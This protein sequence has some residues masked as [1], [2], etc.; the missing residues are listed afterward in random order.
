MAGTTAYPGALDT[1]TNLNENL[2]DNVDTV[3]AA[4]QNN[5]NAAIKAVQAKVGIGADTATTTQILVGGASAGSSAWVTMSGNAT[6]TNAGVVS[7]TG[8]SFTSTLYV[9]ESAN[10]SMGLGVT[11]NQGAND[12]EVL[13]FKSSDIAHAYT[14]GGETD[15]YAAF[16][17]SSA[18][19]GGLKITSIAEDAAEDQVTQ[20]HSI[21][22]TA[23]TT[24]STSGVGLVDIYVAEHNGSNALADITADG[25][26]FSVRARVGSADV[27][28]F[29]VDEDG[30]AY[31]FGNAIVT[32]SVTAAGSTLAAAGSKS[33]VASG[34][35]GSAGLA[36]ALNA[37][38]TV[39]VVADNRAD[40]SRP[41]TGAEYEAADAEYN[42]CGYNED[43]G[44]IWVAYFDRGVS[45]DPTVCSG[46]V[47]G[48]TITWGTPLAIE[49][50]DGHKMGAVYDTTLNQLWIVY[51]DKAASAYNHRIASCTFGGTGGRTVTKNGTEKTIR[52]GDSGAGYHENQ[53]FFND[54][55]NVTIAAITDAGNSHKTDI[56]K[57]SISGSTITA[58]ASSDITTA[59]GVN[60]VPNPRY[61][62]DNTNAR[63]MRVF[64]KAQQLYCEAYSYNNSTPT[65][66]KTVGPI[67][68]TG[69]WEVKNADN[70][71]NINYDNY[72]K[73]THVMWRA[74]HEDSLMIRAMRL[75]GT[76]L[77]L[78]EVFMAH[79]GGS[80][81]NRGVT[82][83][84]PP[85]AY[86]A[87]D[88]LG[89]G[90]LLLTYNSLD[91]YTRVLPLGIGDNLEYTVAGTEQT[92]SYTTGSGT[93][94]HW[95]AAGHFTAGKMIVCWSNNAGNE[96]VGNIYTMP[97]GAT[98]APKFFGIS[99]AAIS[100]T[101]TGSITIVGGVNTG[102]SGLTR[103]DD[104]YLT[105]AGAY[106]ST[107]S[108][109]NYGK[110]GTATASNNILLTGTGDQS[111]SDA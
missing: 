103:G 34:A 72:N 40:G 30:D 21:G 8:G 28:R 110:I 56:W 91:D 36:V 75:S 35:I 84:Y 109:E 102:V 43:T 92:M 88:A 7:V 104:I 26:V 108:A 64:V 14:T 69:G 86:M 63:I 52:A 23:M 79:Q 96:G 99:E 100:D 38:G 44:G 87:N 17:K 29:M 94:G 98:T 24:K 32:G 57:L 73:V 106:S 39:S 80:S 58:T 62:W 51:S 67:G 77:K 13:A 10:G 11:I 3:A 101:A 90:R 107:P 15:T 55:D 53:V 105:A 70:S 65:I 41:S 59:G 31:I 111:V 81:G 25:N 85:I 97:T 9:N 22:G 50:I 33:M 48:S 89:T 4:H 74:E 27:T 95:A 37:D 5:Q 61:D 20:I 66:A 47:S 6:M 60:A 42:V 19:L 71:Y 76:D 2:A 18:T 1:N 45:G 82:S 46:S 12:D 83:S 68:I 16:Q 93:A 78:G 49:N 54:T